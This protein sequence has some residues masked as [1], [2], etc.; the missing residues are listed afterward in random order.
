M[1]MPKKDFPEINNSSKEEI[2]KEKEISFSYSHGLG[3]K[4][5]VK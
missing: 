2:E 3:Y 4:A 1:R 5:V